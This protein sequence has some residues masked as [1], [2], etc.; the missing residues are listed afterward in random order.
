M[1]GSKVVWRL[2]EGAT[3]KHQV[4]LQES[5][6]AWQ[7]LP[8]K[9]VHLAA[10]ENPPQLIWR[11]SG[12]VDRGVCLF[13]CFVGVLK[14]TKQNDSLTVAGCLTQLKATS[15]YYQGESNGPSCSCAPANSLVSLPTAWPVLTEGISGKMSWWQRRIQANSLTTSHSL[16]HTFIKLLFE[17][18]TSL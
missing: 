7:K 12:A 3:P 11:T 10:E 4:N 16:T 15:W 14:E 6:G 9:K 13:I 18:K 17:S 5:Q 8:S 1:L 2:A